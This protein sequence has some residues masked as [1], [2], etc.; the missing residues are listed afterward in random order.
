MHSQVLPGFL[1]VMSSNLTILL[2]VLLLGLVALAAAVLTHRV[3]R[4]AQ[5]RLLDLPN[6]R[7]SHI[8]PT[9]RGGGLAIVVCFGV[10]L[11]GLFWGGL[12]P[13]PLALALAGL[14]PLSVIGFVD[15]HGHVP[16]RW[17]F[18]VQAVAVI[19]A[20]IWIGGMERIEVAGSAYTIGWM[21][22]F[23]AALF[24]LW[25]LNLFNFMDG[26]D[27]IAGVE[28]VT[29]SLSAMVLM[30]FSIGTSLPAEA[31][32]ALVLAAATSGFLVWNWPPAKIFMGDVGSGV[33]GFTLALLALWSAQHHALSLTVW[34]ILAA[35][36][37]VDATLTLMIRIR[38]GERW[39]EAHRSH[40]YQH[41]ARRWS[42]HRKVTLSVL[43]INLVWLLPLA[44]LAMRH[45]GG[46]LWLL[47]IAIL[48][49][50]FS[51]CRLGAGR[52]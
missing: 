38:Q 16:A 36:F 5:Y 3:W 22:D 44:W 13:Q 18:L 51:A 7:S 25:M 49:L 42:S 28:T 14:V 33:L 39:Y 52:S 2:G 17:R 35:V 27:G 31:Y 1:I 4:Y 6:D 30:S 40:A 19:W 34:L 46:E 32:V 41:A 26:I 37:L 23:L 47:L 10:T 50:F 20:L 9:P 24:M 11:A 29:V 8:Q 43:A 21:G 48:P 12:L 15:D 45:P